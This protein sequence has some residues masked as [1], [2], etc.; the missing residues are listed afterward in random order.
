MNSLWKGF[1]SL[2]D[3]MFPKSLEE[4]MTDLDDRM[5]NF[6]DQMG[7]GIYK[8]PL[9]TSHATYINNSWS[10]ATEITK[11]YEKD[12]VSVY[13]TADEFLKEMIKLVPSGQFTPYAYY[14][15]DMDS[16]ECYFKDESCYTQ[17]LNNMV[18]LH[19]S[20]ENKEIVGVN[21][22]GVKNLIENKGSF[23]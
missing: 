8:N 3:W 6:Y 14:N 16:I 21:I 7:W 20:F 15:K 13:T 12:Q 2:F 22:L 5:Q 11:K 19:L 1:I 17:P 18:E 4:Q 23:K 9:S 10:V